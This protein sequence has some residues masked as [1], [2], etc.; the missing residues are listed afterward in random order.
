MGDKWSTLKAVGSIG[1]FF[2][3]SCSEWQNGSQ[4]MVR[5]FHH[6][7]S[8]L[9]QTGRHESDRWRPGKTEQAVTTGD[10]SPFLMYSVHHRALSLCG[11]GINVPW[12]LHMV[13]STHCSW[14]SCA[15]WFVRQRN[16]FFHE[17]ILH[18]CSSLLLHNSVLW[19]LGLSPQYIH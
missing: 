17:V 12:L 4:S 7:H 9:H 1:F 19:F 13:V 18:S 6:W 15:K 2:I 5:F 3:H 8:S 11:W 10:E 14:T 16:F